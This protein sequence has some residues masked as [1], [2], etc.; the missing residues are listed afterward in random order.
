MESACVSFLSLESF[1]TT[2]YSNK[3]RQDTRIKDKKH[4]W[5]LRSTQREDFKAQLDYCKKK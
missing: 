2:D 1:A 5:K 3:K 4:K